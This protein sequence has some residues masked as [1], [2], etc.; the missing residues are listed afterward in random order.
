MPR[1]CNAVKSQ[2][3]AKEWKSFVTIPL[4][5]MC[6][7][8]LKSASLSS[9]LF[10]EQ[11]FSHSSKV[12]IRK[13]TY[14]FQVYTYKVSIEEMTYRWKTENSDGWQSID[15]SVTRFLHL[16]VRISHSKKQESAYGIFYRPTCMPTCG[17]YGRLI[18]KL[19]S[20][21]AHKSGKLPYWLP[22]L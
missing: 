14:I 13:K 6:E 4:Q 9:E 2:R 12:L 10:L 3:K 7:H 20:L 22:M 16:R 21:I 1:Y 19:Y 5:G 8:F 18:C 15:Y 11:S 17:L